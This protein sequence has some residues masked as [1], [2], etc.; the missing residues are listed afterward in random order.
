MSASEIISTPAS[1][2]PLVEIDLPA[3]RP[4]PW[5]DRS[6]PGPS[7]AIGVDTIEERGERTALLRTQGGWFVVHDRDGAAGPIDAPSGAVWLGL[8]IPGGDDEVLSAAPGGQLYAASPREAVKGKFRELGQV[9]GAQ[10]WDAAGK[11]VAAGTSWDE[12]FVSADGGKSFRKGSVG[13]GQ[14]ITAVFARSDGVVVARARPLAGGAETTYVSRGGARWAK[15]RFQPE[16]LEQVG[17]WIWSGAD[18]PTVLAR[19]GVRWVSADVY[20]LAERDTWPRL[21]HR[22]YAVTAFALT[23]RVTASRPPAPV[24]KH[25]ASGSG[26]CTAE[27]P[28]IESSPAAKSRQVID[29]RRASSSQ[30]DAT[31][32][33]ADKLR[34]G[35]TA[36]AP[37]IRVACRGVDCLRQSPGPAPEPTSSL[38]SFISDGSCEAQHA[39]KVTGLCADGAPL[40]RKPHAMRRNTAQLIDLPEECRPAG[41]L[42]ARGLGLLICHA[43]H[44]AGDRSIVYSIDRDLA[45]RKEAELRARADQLSAVTMADDGTILLPLPCSD[46]E[47]CRVFARRPLAAGAPDAWREIAVPGALTY[48]AAPDGTALAVAADSGGALSFVLDTPDKGATTIASGIAPPA[49]IQEI[50]I[51][52]RGYIALSVREQRHLI[53]Y[54]VASDGTLRR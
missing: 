52:S 11:I 48:R 8:G 28:A 1:A 51:T 38:L 5:L 50:A 16:S 2:A 15:S 26:T 29:D 47:P 9:P 19:D 12:V 34:E 45:W 40:V 4:A 7:D 18:C 54:Y 22:S 21:L 32:S 43:S 39:D 46:A 6:E 37:S 31:G 13:D 23:S 25:E 35:G 27:A 33:L 36:P 42:S 3:P 17:A 49:N 24:G 10:I 53:L 30:P 44:A 14:M 20:A 41:A